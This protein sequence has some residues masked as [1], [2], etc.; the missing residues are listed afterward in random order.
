MQQQTYNR[1][2]K[3]FVAYLDPQM[4]TRTQL[5]LNQKEV[6]AYFVKVMKHYKDDKEM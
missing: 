2:R 4:V 6:V 5:C 1:K 3:E